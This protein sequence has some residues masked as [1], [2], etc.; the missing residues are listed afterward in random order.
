MRRLVVCVL[1]GLWA[2]QAAAAG[3]RPETVTLRGDWGQASFSIEIADTP[4]ERSLG[5][6]HRREMPRRSGMLFVYET[7]RPASFWMKNTLIE[8]DMLFADSTGLITHVHHRAIPGDLSPIFGG[9]EVFAVLEINGGL[10]RSYGITVGSLMQ[11]AVFI[12]GPAAWPC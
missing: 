3:C 8:L 5:L 2:A 1:L 10:A 7:P 6:M 12:E 4:E 11:H 9:N